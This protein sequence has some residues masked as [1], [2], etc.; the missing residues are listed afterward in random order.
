LISLSRRA[1]SQWR[2]DT[3]DGAP[4]RGVLAGAADPATRAGMCRPR[5]ARLNKDSWGYCESD[6][7][8][9]AKKRRRAGTK[10]HRP[11]EPSHDRKYVR[12][13]THACVIRAS[14]RSYL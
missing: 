14:G 1:A 9:R 2:I 5:G 13:A 10:I 8:S 11:L 7:D 6:L 3:A 12:L 4:V